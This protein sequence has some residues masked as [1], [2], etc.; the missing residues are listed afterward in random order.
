MSN[1]ITEQTRLSSYWLAQILRVYANL[2]NVIAE[3]AEDCEKLAHILTERDMERITVEDGVW[4]HIIIHHKE[5]Q[6]DDGLDS[7]AT[8]D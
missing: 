2:P 5:W 4:Q 3:D 1:D 6:D 7:F 8:V